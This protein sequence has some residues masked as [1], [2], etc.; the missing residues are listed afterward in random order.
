MGIFERV[1]LVGLPEKS[2]GQKTGPAP[3]NSE[4]IVF[5]SSDFP[6]FSGETSNLENYQ[7]LEASKYNCLS[8]CSTHG[9]YMLTNSCIVRPPTSCGFRCLKSLQ[10]N[11]ENLK[12]SSVAE[13]RAELGKKK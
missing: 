5:F 6:H 10:K 9:Y 13:M 3:R 2:D 8:K 12:E 11:V 1:R 4:F 7:L